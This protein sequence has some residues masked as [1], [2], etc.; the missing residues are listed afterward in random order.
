MSAIED[1]ESV[2]GVSFTHHHPILT[3]ALLLPSNRNLQ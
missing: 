3:E 2:D 1:D